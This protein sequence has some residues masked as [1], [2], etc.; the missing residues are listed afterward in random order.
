MSEQEIDD[1]INNLKGVIR[2]SIAQINNNKT[3]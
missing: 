3:L 2:V 1:K